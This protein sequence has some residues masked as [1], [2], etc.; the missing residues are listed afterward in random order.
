MSKPLEQRIDVALK[1]IQLHRKKWT[2]MDQL[3][4]SDAHELLNILENTLNGARDQSL[5][6]ALRYLQIGLRQK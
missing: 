6:Q 2:R 4:H 5:E 3:S 1:E